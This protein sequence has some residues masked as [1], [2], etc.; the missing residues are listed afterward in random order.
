MMCSS[1]ACSRKKKLITETVEHTTGK[2]TSPNIRARKPGT[3]P[4]IVVVVR[5]DHPLTIGLFHQE[6]FDDSQV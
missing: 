3:N 5:A 6:E 1:P 2:K 4:Y